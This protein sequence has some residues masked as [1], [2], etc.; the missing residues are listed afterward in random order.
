M[1]AVPFRGIM[2]SVASAFL[3][4]A[5]KGSISLVVL[6]VLTVFAVLNIYQQL[7]FT[8]VPR[9]RVQRCSHFRTSKAEECLQL[10]RA[11]DL[12][13]S[14]IVA[15]FK[16]TLTPHQSRAAPNQRLVAT[17]GIENCFV[18]DQVAYAKHSEYKRYSVSSWTTPNGEI[19]ANSCS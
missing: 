17:F 3:L 15:P 18:T 2:V 14:S 10:L 13:S 11:K 4:F 12:P 9:N 5:L 8:L 1:P 19:C 7:P 16:N 6:T